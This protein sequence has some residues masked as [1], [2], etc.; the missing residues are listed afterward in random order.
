MN[1]FSGP[2]P[3]HS[4]QGAPEPSFRVFVMGESGFGTEPL[5][6]SGQLRVGSG[7]DCEILVEGTAAEH[8]LLTIGGGFYLEDLGSAQGTRVRGESVP[9]G[10]R[11]SLAPGDP[12]Q[13]GETLLMIEPRP[14]P[15]PRRLLPGE[16]LDLRLEEECHRAERIRSG[17][18]ML[19]VVAEPA[20]AVRIE[21]LLS[22]S[23][24]LQ[25][26]LAQTGPAEF[27]ILLLETPPRQAELV[28]TRLAGTLEAA[29]ARATIRSASY[30]RDGRSPDALQEA[31]FPLARGPRASPQTDPTM[32]GLDALLDRVAP[33]NIN[34]LVR[35]ETGV[36]KERCAQAL[37]DRSR[38]AKHPFLVL[39]CGALPE[40]LLEGELFGYERGAFTGAQ[41]AKQGLLETAEGGT[42]F[43]DEIGELPL[44]MQSKLL[45]VLEERRVLRLGG[46]KS[47]AIDVRFVAATN[48]DLELEVQQGTFR[49]D[50][51]FRLNG[52]TLQIPPL[53]ERPDEILPLAHAFVE[54]AAVRF[55]RP[56]P[57]LSAEVSSALRAYAWPG[58]IRELRNVIERA[59]LLCDHDAIEVSHV[60]AARLA[61][62]FAPRRPARAAPAGIAGA[63]PTPT[64]MPPVPAPTE[65]LRE[66]LATLQRER[67]VEA[68]ARCAGNQTQ[69][70]LELGMSRR[71]LVKRL[72]EYGLPRP[73]KRLP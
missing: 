70:A 69:A 63:I 29:G 58:N 65:E 8:A 20:S 22:T 47:K 18:T 50:L 41:Q 42:V 64:P 46:L 6:V 60:P 35:G 72:S 1:G 73:R 52:I 11:V 67:I 5:P 71:T 38:R 2:Q 45:R 55:E 24:R 10:T 44:L 12:V 25:D 13:L 51:Y 4:Q 30:P 57:R 14:S 34:V 43:L 7:P 56:A 68:L 31:L 62:S 36:G 61:A 49:Q 3:G 27:L 53:R 16:Y 59:V 54:Q 39:N 40:A 32:R 15:P 28:A 48:R 19:R 9:K 33:A 66:E 17:F 26:L 21:D 37:H 23:L